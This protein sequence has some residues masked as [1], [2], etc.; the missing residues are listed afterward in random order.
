MCAR[1]VCNVSDGFSYFAQMLRDMRGGGVE[2]SPH[3]FRL[4]QILLNAVALL[5]I[6]GA[7]F[8]YFRANPAVQVEVLTTHLLLLFLTNIRTHIL[9]RSN[10][11]KDETVD[12]LH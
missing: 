11:I 12:Q 6:T 1:F 4:M 2:G 5:A 10:I 7:L 8:A 3:R 9:S